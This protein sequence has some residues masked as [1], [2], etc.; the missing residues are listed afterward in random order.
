MTFSV[1]RKS[2]RNNRFV[3][4]WF[5]SSSKCT[6]NPFSA[7][8]LSR[9]PLEIGALT[10]RSKP[11]SWLRLGRGKHPVNSTPL[12]FASGL[13][14]YTPP[15][16][17]YTT[18]LHTPKHFMVTVRSTA[19][20]R[21]PNREP[22]SNTN[23]SSAFVTV[24]ASRA[25]VTFQKE[26]CKLSAIETFCAPGKLDQ[27]S[28]KSLK[29]RYAPIPSMSNTAKFCRALTKMCHI[30]TVQNFC[31]PQKSA[32]V[33]QIREKVTIGQSPMPNFVALRQKAC[34]IF[35]VE[36]MC[37]RKKIGPKFTKIT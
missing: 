5:S 3:T 6:K 32:K 23:L 31:S 25:Y 7:G 13:G 35:D 2:V 24:S 12:S 27:S 33:H 17:Q 37:S 28:P 29:T 21:H 18:A 20:I 22:N 11:S 14:D 26:V 19:I 1:C 15:I 30:P 16:L 36:Q 8:A 4:T 34:E 9:T 10:T